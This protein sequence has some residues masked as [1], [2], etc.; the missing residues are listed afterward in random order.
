MDF[1]KAARQ[2]YSGML[3][4]NLVSVTILGNYVDYYIHIYIYYG[5]LLEVSLKGLL[6]IVATP[7]DAF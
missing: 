4:R 5:N 1:L 7:G 2:P 6:S 3:L